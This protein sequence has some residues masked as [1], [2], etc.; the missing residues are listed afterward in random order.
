MKIIEIWPEIIVE[1]KQ[2]QM[3]N[4][5]IFLQSGSDKRQGT[6]LLFHLNEKEERFSLI[7]S[8]ETAAIL[9]IKWSHCR[10]R[11]KIVFGIVNAIGQLVVYELL[12]LS[13]SGSYL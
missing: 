1:L 4:F 7:R 8:V 11:E 9:D 3:L 13:T 5:L 2:L 6:L 12:D 10:I